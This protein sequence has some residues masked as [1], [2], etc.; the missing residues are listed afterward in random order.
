M[1]KN[2][3]ESLQSLLQL[4]I[5]SDIDFVVI[6]GFA[7]ILHGST[8]ITQDIDICAQLTLEH[9][10]KFRTLLASLHPFHRM[11][12]QRI[13]FL[14][15]HPEEKLIK[16]LYLRTDLGVLDI[17][18]LLPDVGDFETL[19]SRADIFEIE[20]KKVKV[21]CLDDLIKAKTLVGREKDKATVLELKVIRE[22]TKT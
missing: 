5:E 2:Y 20:G 3:P 8:Q 22:K 1:Q 18:S 19:A 21:L 16:N 14:E 11:T 9:I 7:A 17:L 4:L 15:K 6:G 12:P 13:S 10:E